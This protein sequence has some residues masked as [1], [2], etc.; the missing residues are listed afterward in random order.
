VQKIAAG[1][2]KGENRSGYYGNQRGRVSVGV[3]VVSDPFLIGFASRAWVR[4]GLDHE[5]F[6]KRAVKLRCKRNN[7]PSVSRKE[8]CWQVS[9]IRTHN[10]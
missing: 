3:E 10:D 5:E 9:C 2:G 6:D 1:W 4:E 8:N 7:T